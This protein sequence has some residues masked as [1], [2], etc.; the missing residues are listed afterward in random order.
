MSTRTRADKKIRK[1]MRFFFKS[2]QGQELTYLTKQNGLLKL[3]AAIALVVAFAEAA[4]ITII[5]LRSL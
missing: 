5:I 1:E 3:L 2:K 4:V